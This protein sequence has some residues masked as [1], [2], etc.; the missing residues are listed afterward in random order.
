[1]PSAAA[2]PFAGEYVDIAFSGTKETHA[3]LDRVIADAH[4]RRFDGVHS[5]RRRG[6][7]GARPD[8]RTRES[9][10]A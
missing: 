5:P 8:C 10:V 9:R 6:R 7:V 1:M 2:G 4:R 3:E